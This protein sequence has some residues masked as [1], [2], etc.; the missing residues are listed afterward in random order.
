[1]KKREKSLIGSL[2]LLATIAVVVTAFGIGFNAVV[3]AKSLTQSS[4]EY[5][6]EAMNDGYRTEIKSQ[7]QSTMAVLQAEYDLYQ[8]GAK[9]EDEAKYDASETIRAMRYRDD[10]SGYFWIDDTDYILVMHPILV[11]KEGD[12]RYE[13]EDPNGVMIIQEIMKTCQSPEKGGYNEFYFTKADGVTVAPKIAYSQIFEP[14]GWVVS[15]GNYTD[16]IQAAIAEKGSAIDAVYQSSLAKIDAVFAAMVVA[17]L[18]IAYFYGKRLIRPLKDIQRFANNISEGNLTT[19]VSVKANNEIGR[20][21]QALDTA[22]NN[23]RSL[24]HG[25]NDLAQNVT[26]AL[27]KFEDTFNHMK[28]SISEVSTAVESIANNVTEQAGSTD[29]AAQQ[30]AIMADRIEKT[31]V[32]IHNMD[33]NANDMKQ[34]SQRSMDTLN[35]LIQANDKTRT[36]ISAMHSQTEMTNKSVQQ[37]QLAANLINEI[38]DQTSLLALNA[39]I[40]AARAGEA[41]KGFAVVADEIGKLSQQSADSVEEITGVLQELLSNSSKSVEIMKEMSSSIDVQV[42][43]LS[44]TQKIF[45]QLYKELDSCVS[46]V[47][48]I[49][50]MTTEIG[51]QRESVT[52]ALDTLNRIAQENATVTEET[53]AMSCELSQVVNDSGAIVDDL[54]TKVD[55]LVQSVNK[56]TI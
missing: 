13:L 39:S 31:T 20:T 17:A 16:D 2:M 26:A 8:S 33:E 45:N 51:V 14:W 42:D 55:G 22:Q 49:D 46:I 50:A 43:S 3:T 53:A 29:D 6:E 23:I 40:E 24:L 44:E 48:D 18:L 36:N 9:T 47:Q 56:F 32:G 38:S 7:V 1:M 41:G 12:Y 10:Q 54:E 11:D 21:A 25:I 5:Y 37:I 27:S 15:T 28:G 4:F 30:A 34:L 52:S 19:Q 35:K